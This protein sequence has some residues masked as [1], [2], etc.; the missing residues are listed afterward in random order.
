MRCTVPLLKRPTQDFEPA[1]VSF[2][3]AWTLAAL[4]MGLGGICNQALADQTVVIDER[5]GRQFDGMGT[6]SAGGAA[7]VC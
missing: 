2:R 1:R 3:A 5:T 6:V 4:A 7:S